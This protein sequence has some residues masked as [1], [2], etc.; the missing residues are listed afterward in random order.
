MRVGGSSRV[1]ASSDAIL[2]HTHASWR[3]KSRKLTDQQF[4]VLKN[5]HD[6][7]TSIHPLSKGATSNT[8]TQHSSKKRKKKERE[9]E[10]S[11]QHKTKSNLNNHAREPARAPAAPGRSYHATMHLRRHPRPRLYVSRAALVQ[12]RECLSCCRCR[13]RC[14]AGI[15]S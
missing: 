6:M 15:H 5:Q 1:V 2:Q 4:I 7:Y 10:A 12:V 11:K 14:W 13:C 8:D 9:Q 3:T